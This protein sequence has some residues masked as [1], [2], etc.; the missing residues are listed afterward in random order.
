MEVTVI[1]QAPVTV[2]A[3][4]GSVDGLT[5]ESLTQALAAQLDGGHSQLVAD[6][7]GVSYISSAG[8]RSLLITLKS[9]RAK[10]GDFRLAAVQ[11]SVL[12]VLSMAGF[13]KLIK[14]FDSTT[15]AVESFST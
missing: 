3:I 7:S 5:A 1:T 11:P 13:T 10:N 14:V 2:L 6:L 8:L 4:Q 15:L 9:A 12:N